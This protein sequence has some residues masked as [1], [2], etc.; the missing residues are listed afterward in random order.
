[1][2]KLLNLGVAGAGVFGGY[3]AGQYAKM[4]DVRLAAVYDPQLDRA[5]ALADRYG[6]EA[7]DALDAFIDGIEA[8][9]VTSP[10]STHAAVAKKAA[11][12]GRH[13]YVEKPL[14]TTVED[15]EGLAAL[16]A[17]QGLT[18]AVG[19]QERMVFQAMGLFDVPERP[20]LVEAVRRSPFSPRNG[21][22]SCVLDLMIHDID[23]ALALDASDPLAV[24]ADGRTT[25]GPFL[26]EVRAEATFTSG[27]TAIFNA[28][29]I[30]EAR[31]R[32]MRIVFPSG[33]VEIDFLTRE[34]KNA[35]P[36][37]LDPSFAETAVGKDPLGAALRGF[38]QA[39]RDRGNTP[40]PGAALAPTLARPTD[41]VRAL[42][43]AL[44]VEQAAGG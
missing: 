22:V 16:A 14:A 23:L 26:D 2:T 12:A 8:L 4:D 42:D 3:H 32:R 1:M 39:V 17:S 34:F 15:A 9:S 18:L 35:T 19:H 38:V 25:H 43:L 13:L 29:R 24:E 41:G 36:F 33:E 11:Q 31:E 37:V 7:F 10:A 6:A 44:A 27:L 21:D 28:S 20:V 40:R 30:A 5:K